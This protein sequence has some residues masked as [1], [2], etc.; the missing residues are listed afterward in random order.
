MQ[1]NLVLA[2]GQWCFA[3]GKVT[4]GLVESNGCIPPA[5]D[6][7]HLQAEQQI[8]P[9]T[10]WLLSA[11]YK[12]HIPSFVHSFVYSFIQTAC[13]PEPTCQLPLRQSDGSC[14]G[15]VMWCWQITAFWHIQRSLHVWGITGC[16]C[17]VLSCDFGFIDLNICVQVQ[18][19]LWSFILCG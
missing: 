9:D 2:V 15:C 1:Y 13:S 14:W 10:S 12:I 11:W 17:R 3:A 7:S 5:D 6:L 19:M 4:S 8:K 16:S 18:D